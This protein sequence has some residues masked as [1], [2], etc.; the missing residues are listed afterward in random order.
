MRRLW[1]LRGTILNGRDER[2]Q[3]EAIALLVTME[4]ERLTGRTYAP[5]LDTILSLLGS[6]ST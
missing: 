5:P 6:T 2:A 3:R 1:Q 4:L